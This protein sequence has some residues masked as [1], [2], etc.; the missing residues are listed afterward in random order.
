MGHLQVVLNLR[1]S[2]TMCGVIFYLYKQN[3]P[4]HCIATPKIKLQPEDGPYAGPKHVVV[5]P[6][7]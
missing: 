6:M 4:A 1:S 7:Y 2:Y 3:N 5:S